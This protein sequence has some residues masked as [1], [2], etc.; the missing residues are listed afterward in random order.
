MRSRRGRA[1]SFEFLRH[2]RIARFV[3]VEIYSVNAD[4]MFYFAFSELSQMRAPLRILLEVISD[5][6]SLSALIALLGWL[7]S[8]RVRRPRRRIR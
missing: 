7:V 1:S 6:V 4:A 3:S 2:F 5:A 8:G